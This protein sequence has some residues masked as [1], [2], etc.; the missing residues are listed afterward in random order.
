[1]DGTLRAGKRT[2]SRCLP[3]NQIMPVLTE[4]SVVALFRRGSASIRRR[5]KQSGT[6]RK[7]C[8]V[9]PERL[10]VFPKGLGAL[11]QGLRD[12]PE[13]LGVLPED[14]GVLPEDLGVLPEGLGVPPES[15]GVPPESLGVPPE[16]LGVP[17]ESLGVPPEGLG[18]PPEGL[19]VLP[20]GLWAFREGEKVFPE[21]LF[22]RSVRD[23]RGP[24]RGP[25]GCLNFCVRVLL[26]GASE[27]CGSERLPA[28]RPMQSGAS[29]ARC[30]H[31]AAC[32]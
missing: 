21:G 6:F 15:L 4:T 3:E 31:G 10:G 2:E 17:P 18:V 14:L 7:C 30:R 24:A 20:Q 32:V 19:G 13:S 12:P 5:S 9:F 27:P 22:A 23:P 28:H 26:S 25:Q 11:P 8:Q 29:A 1:M 16:S